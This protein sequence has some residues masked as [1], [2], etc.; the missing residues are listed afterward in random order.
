MAS[1]YQTA[2]PVGRGG[3]GEILKAWDPALD[4][5]VALKLLHRDDP[6]LAA[7][8]QRE[9]QAQARVEH[10]NVCRVYE[11]GELDGR[12]Y[13]AMQYIE[14]ETLDAVAPRLDLEQRIRMLAKVADAVHAAH[15]VGLIHRDLKPAN[16]MV[17][18][19]DDGEIVPW[20][21]DFGISRV[22]D[23]GG[24]TVTGQV[25][26]SPGYIAPE[27]VRGDRSLDRRADVFSLGAI[28][29]E[30]V[31]GR[32]AFPSDS[33]VEAL[34][35]VLSHDPVPPRRV[36]PGVPADLET[37]ILK[38][39][40][41]E[42]AD[43][44]GSAR[45]VADELGRFLEGE[46][47]AARPVGALGRLRRKARR[48]PVVAA[49]LTGVAAV[50]GLLLLVL[51][52]GAVKYTLDLRRER[53]AAVEAR[54]EAEEVAT[55]LASLFE[56]SDP[57]RARGEDLSAREI[58]A[59]GAQRVRDE[60]A[61]RPAVQARLQ[62]TIGK[63]Q[64]ELGLFDDAGVQ[65]EAAVAT[66]RLLSGG[67]PPGL[68]ERLGLADSAYE[69]ARVRKDQGRHA[70][71]AELAAESARIREAVLGTEDSAVAE[72]LV[73]Q[74]AAVNEGK[75]PGDP[76]VIYRKALAIQRAAVGDDHTEVGRIL[77]NLAL[78]HSQRGEMKESVRLLEEAVAIFER[79]HGRQHPRYAEALQN[80][81]SALGVTD[82]PRGIDV[83]GQALE[84]RVELLGPEHPY[85]GFSQNNLGMLYLAWGD[86]VEAERLF[87][88]A[89]ANADAAGTPRLG[90]FRPVLAY[91]LCATARELGR[92]AEAE[93][94]CR[95]GLEVALELFEGKESAS[96]IGNRH[97]LA[98]L[99]LA[100]ERPQAA[101]AQFGEAAEL[102]ARDLG[103]T[104]VDTLRARIGL[105]RALHAAG[106]L[107]AAEEELVE[108]VALAE[109]AWDQENVEL[110]EARLALAAV[111]VDRAVQR[112]AEAEAP[113][114]TLADL[115][116]IT[117]ESP[118]T[119]GVAAGAHLLLARLAAAVAD[120]AGAE[121]H[122]QAAI[123]LLTPV[124][125]E[126]PAV[127]YRVARAA[128]LEA[129]RD[130]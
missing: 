104:A 39:L 94:L 14:G 64:R 11:V 122:R 78:L 8:F 54:E 92:L 116:A 56:S 48:H 125:A 90:F 15:R 5:W 21:L 2:V 95:E 106:R 109:E 73:T 12:P 51:V 101:V 118:R 1:K 62:H 108:V 82:L 34:V 44:Y 119:T 55:F 113:A 52:A 41:K 60:L 57:S 126:N 68:S 74:A 66:R 53:A 129:L 4:R 115:A 47:V 9:A 96:S 110:L 59:R 16:V 17:D 3:M 70:E 84:L 45:E 50:V 42:P 72:A 37:V 105:G 23:A 128:A 69:L 86:W 40:E 24:V 27:Q 61:A 35:K 80:L 20:V 71:A 88:A 85:V 33:A 26:G 120:A 83:L 127:R 97:G 10:P 31:V 22:H 43:R 112:G 49:L 6:D 32:P 93:S 30:V 46:P 121:A 25:L 99:A 81:G 29:Y 111:R 13:I 18:E 36:D 107:E 7:R 124:V 114:Q 130:S 75:L 103:P 98:E 63:V 91:N 89:R 87:V 117:P 123:E 79:V 19:R 67:E 76:A 65:L 100:R 77:N 38:C 28:L 102:A 58:L